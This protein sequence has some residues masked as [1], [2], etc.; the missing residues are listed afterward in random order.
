MADVFNPALTLLALAAPRLRGTWRGWLPALRYVVAGLAGLGLIYGVAALDAHFGLWPAVGLDYSTH[1]AYAVSLATTIIC[2][3]RRWRTLLA[4]AICGH[5][6]LMIVLGFHSPED[7]ATTA[8]IA[9]PAA[10][11]TMKF[12][13]PRQE[14]SRIQA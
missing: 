2:W 10:W 4:V 5:A 7:L 1:M 6:L 9:T 14:S 13:G 12:L 8:V 11:A 3:D